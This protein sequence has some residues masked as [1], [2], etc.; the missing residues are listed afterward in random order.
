MEHCGRRH[1]TPAAARALAAGCVVVAVL[2]ASGCSTSAFPDAETV[3]TLVGAGAPAAGWVADDPERPESFTARFASRSDI[4]SEGDGAPDGIRTERRDGAIV[5]TAPSEAPTSVSVAWLRDLAPSDSA[6]VCGELA[7]WLA[8]EVVPLGVAV[9]P[10][11]TR[12]ACTAP[13]VTDVAVGTAMTDILDGAKSPI[14]TAADGTAGR[15]AVSVLT[16]A[17]Q[18]D[19]GSVTRRELYVALG[20]EAE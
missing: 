12:A 16:A 5:M 9:R 14:V 19:A 8:A 11:E 1:T 2:T 18:P 20:F 3:D 6:Q 7:D 10:G 4:D 13:G 15:W 17:G